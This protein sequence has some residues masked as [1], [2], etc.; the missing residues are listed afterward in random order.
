MGL[1]MI[2]DRNMVGAGRSADMRFVVLLV[3]PILKMV[4]LLLAMVSFVGGL[5]ATRVRP[6]RPEM[7]DD[8]HDFG[9]R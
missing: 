6:V 7:Y 8:R 5:R 9:P 3:F 2:P 4:I 1:M